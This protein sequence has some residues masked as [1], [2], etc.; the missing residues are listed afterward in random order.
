[1]AERTCDQVSRC[2]RDMP[3]FLVMEVLERAA[4]LERAG[5]SIIHL[6]VGEFDFD[7]EKGMRR[8]GDFL[9]GLRAR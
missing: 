2:A 9:D 5:R 3:P 7:I 1:M 6:E 8:L 4:A